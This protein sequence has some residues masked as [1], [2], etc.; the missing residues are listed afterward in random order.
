MNS[1]IEYVTVPFMGCDV[2][3]VALD[4]IPVKNHL[5]A[6]LAAA[7]KTAN[8]WRDLGFSPKP[9]A[10]K[11]NLHP[12]CMAKRT[13]TYFYKDDVMDDCGHTPDESGSYLLHEDHA[14][15]QLRRVHRTWRSSQLW[16]HGILIT[17]ALAKESFRLR[18]SS[19]S[20]FSD[21][22]TVLTSPNR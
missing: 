11:F 19:L 21:S 12:N 22:R 13:Y 20:P 18:R 15:R 14:Y 6:P 5:P 3:A 16:L 2:L 7:L 9:G 4:G 10:K 1:A 8:Q 17:H